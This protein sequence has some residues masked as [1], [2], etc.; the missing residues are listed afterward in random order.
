MCLL[1]NFLQWF[2]FH[3]AFLLGKAHSLKATVTSHLPKGF[4]FCLRASGS[5]SLG[6]HR[7]VSESPITGILSQS[8]VLV[9]AYNFSNDSSAPV[10]SLLHQGC[11]SLSPSADF[12]S[13]MSSPKGGR[14]NPVV[15]IIRLLVLHGLNERC[16]GNKKEMPPEWLIRRLPEA[17]QAKARK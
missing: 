1:E 16:S 14:R 12:A 13:T 9:G 3:P 5:R 7:H 4:P 2:Q 8:C 17:G 11:I 10:P 6:P 15:S